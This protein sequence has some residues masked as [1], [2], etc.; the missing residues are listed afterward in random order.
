VSDPKL[1]E[2]RGRIVKTTGDG[3]LV[4]FP[5]VVDAVC[6]AVEWQREREYFV[7]GIVKEI[8]TAISRQ[9]WL[10]VIARNRELRH[11]TAL[12][13]YVCYNKVILKEPR[14]GWRCANWGIRR[15]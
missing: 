7:D 10:F 1:A 13:R 5:S 6:C 14:C 12:F 15:G 8:T 2:H 11:N 4:E 9:P 3:M